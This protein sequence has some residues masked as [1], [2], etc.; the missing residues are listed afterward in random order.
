MAVSQVTVNRD[1]SSDRI[2]RAA[3][4]LFNARG[5]HGTPVRALARIVRV[6]AAS[7]YY[8][9]PSKQKILAGNAVR[10]FNLA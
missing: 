4:D 1:S 8:H 9:F 10:I 3:I 6:E 7:L 2:R 5:Y